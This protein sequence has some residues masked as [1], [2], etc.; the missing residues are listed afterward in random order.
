VNEHLNG[1][2]KNSRVYI[3]RQK[4]GSLRLVKGYVNW[5]LGV[6]NAK[7]YHV[8]HLP[9]GLNAGTIWYKVF[10]SEAKAM[11]DALTRIQNI[12][13]LETDKA[14]QDIFQ[15]ILVTQ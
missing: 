5:P 4:D 1:I 11:V 15:T 6:V 9:S 2:N 3:V 13:F 12:E 8:D 10:F 7:P 14:A